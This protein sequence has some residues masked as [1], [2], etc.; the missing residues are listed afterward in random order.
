MKYKDQELSLFDLV[1]HH[2]FPNIGIQINFIKPLT[3]IRCYTMI[4]TRYNGSI[5]FENLPFSVISKRFD[6]VGDGHILINWHSPPAEE[7]YYQ[8]LGV[9]QKISETCYSTPWVYL[10]DKDGEHLH[11]ESMASIKFTI[12]EITSNEITLEGKWIDFNL[13]EF[14]FTC[15]FTR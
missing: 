15:R 3:H 2:E 6:F 13:E 4:I 8:F 12:A 7:H 14:N 11:D 1:V 10:T 9:A 5:A